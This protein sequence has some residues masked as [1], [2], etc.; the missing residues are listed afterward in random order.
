MSYNVKGFTS[1]IG[2]L[3]GTLF[4]GTFWPFWLE[5]APIRAESYRRLP[6]GP[7]SSAQVPSPAVQPHPVI[8][9]IE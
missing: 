3:T 5:M 6:R 7:S 8:T 1:R 9:V 4:K 2:G